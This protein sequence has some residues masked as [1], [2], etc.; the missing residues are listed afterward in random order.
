MNNF[1]ENL[2]KIRAERKLSLEQLSI[3]LNLKG[4][5]IS[6]HGLSAYELGKSEPNINTIIA[7]SK[8]FNIS[9]DAILGVN[10]SESSFDSKMESC[11]AYLLNKY[12]HCNTN[13]Y[14]YHTPMGIQSVSTKKYINGN[15]T[16]E[17]EDIIDG[18]KCFDD[19]LSKTIQTIKYIEKN[20]KII[21]IRC[22]PQHI[23][24]ESGK[25]I[26]R[27]RIAH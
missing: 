14:V 23:L 3:L 26:I 6:K 10:Y 20:Y 25:H 7:F 13:E 1:G 2:R 17:M 15:I 4:I 16:G 27:M 24:S 11:F 8:I 19:A 22:M 18:E 21:A 12:P 5:K 9:T